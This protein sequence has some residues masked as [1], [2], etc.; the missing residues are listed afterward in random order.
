MGESRQCV[1]IELVR[2]LLTGWGR[3]SRSGL[4]GPGAYRCPLADLRGGGLPAAPIS[5]DDALT[6]EQAFRDLER[7][8]VQL[9]T[10]L[11]CQHV[12]Q[13]SSYDKI[14]R[15]MH[16]PGARARYEARNLVLNAEQW[17]AGRL[18]DLV[19]KWL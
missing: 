14:A 4:P 12:L 7:Y 19:Q 18:A 8:D 9:A 10:A 17:M 1:P 11:H 16:L 2:S 13:L 15:R 3:W 5:D 6:V